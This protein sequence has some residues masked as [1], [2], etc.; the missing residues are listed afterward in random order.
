[1]ESKNISKGF[2][3][4]VEKITTATGIK[5]A[6]EYIFDKLGMDCGCEERKQKLN[7]LFPYKKPECLTED[8]YMTLKGI[9]TTVKNRVEPSTQK[10]LLAIHNRVFK[11]NK[12]M[13]T[14]GSCVKELVNTMKKLFN[15]YKYEQETQIEETGGK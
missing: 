12:K 7:K 13:S 8:E 14:C 3:D 1:M 2:G 6:T 9:F 15:E 11:T 10:T 4:T 5:K